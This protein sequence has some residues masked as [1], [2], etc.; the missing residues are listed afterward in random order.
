LLALTIFLFIATSV[1]EG[2]A[3]ATKMKHVFDFRRVESHAEIVRIAALQSGVDPCLLAGIMYAES[4]GQVNAVSPAG[5]LGLFQ[6]MLPA[7]ADAAKRLGL[8]EPTREDL[9]TDAGLNARLAASH[10]ASLIRAEGPDLERVLVAYNAG[11]S[12]MLR[13]VREAGGWAAWRRE[14][15]AA[16]DS[17]TLRYAQSVLEY[18]ERFR[19]RGVVAAR[20][21][22]PART[23]DAGLDRSQGRR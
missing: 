13:W 18:T 4:R 3:I 21:S 1:V 9:L 14:H 17:D 16:Q 7:A 20:A 5:A 6:L 11:R 19:E 12:K 8:P 2:P 22:E 15:A 23:S 10:L